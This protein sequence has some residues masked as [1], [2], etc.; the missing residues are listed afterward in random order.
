MN[1]Q[2]LQNCLRSLRD[3]W[4]DL[5]ARTGVSVHTI[6]KIAYGDRKNPCADIVLPLL[7]DP[8]VKK[9]RAA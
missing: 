6:R 2:D 7:S 4:P 9:A 3:E 8:S 5:A 1:I